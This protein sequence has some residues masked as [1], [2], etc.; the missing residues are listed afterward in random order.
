[1]TKQQRAALAFMQRMEVSDEPFTMQAF[2][3]ASG[4]G[5]EN[6]SL[7][8]KLNRS[9]F[10]EFLSA[11]EGGTYKAHGTLGLLP[12]EYARRVSSRSRTGILNLFSEKLADKSLHAAISSIEIYNKPD[13]KYREESFAILMVNAWELLLKAK[14][15]Q[16]NE[17]DEASIHQRDK[18]GKVVYSR[19][20]TPRTITIGEAITAVQLEPVLKDHLFALIELRDNAVHLMNDS[21]MLKVK[22]LEVGTASLRNYLELAK[23]WFQMDLSRY[24]FYL[25][26]MSFFHLHEL[27]S[28]SIHSEQEQHRMLLQ[29]IGSLEEAH[30]NKEDSRYNIGLVLETKFVKSKLRYAPEDPNAIAIKVDAEEAFQKKYRWNYTDHLLPKL[31]ERY[32][33]FKV[34]KRFR[35]LKKQLEANEAYSKVRPL[36]WTKPKGQTKRFYCPDILKEFDKHY[37]RRK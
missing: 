30:S 9:E 5:I 34:D 16:A 11:G 32:K 31:N 21:P 4:Y 8:A 35:A 27:Q 3:D 28:Y 15:I 6:A 25:M 36:D 22:L 14:I 18:E 29:Y 7:T 12:E 33:D 13:F 10:A 37:T 20:G 17:E 2:S 26:P 19:S 23:E 1:M 24:N